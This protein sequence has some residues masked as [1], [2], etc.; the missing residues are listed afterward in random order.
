[1]LVPADGS[2]TEVTGAIPSQW[3]SIDGE[4]V[5]VE[6]SDMNS[7]QT[8]LLRGDLADI[9]IPV[10][11]F[12]LLENFLHGQRTETPPPDEHLHPMHGR[13]LR[14]SEYRERIAT[15]LRAIRLLTEHFATE[16]HLDDPQ[17]VTE[18]VHDNLQSEIWFDFH[19]VTASASHGSEENS[20][21]SSEPWPV[22]LTRF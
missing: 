12:R 10:A 15:I 7:R 5:L 13:T 6:V 17:K 9:K 1:L 18:L 3:S 8:S 21:S 22:F 19:F 14:R 11:H 16:I 2:E 20:I 4:A